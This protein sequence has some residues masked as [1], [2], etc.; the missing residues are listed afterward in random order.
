MG[1]N[2]EVSATHT[3]EATAIL[4]QQ[5]IGEKK[6]IAQ[7]TEDT[8]EQ[9]GPDPAYKNTLEYYRSNQETTQFK[10]EA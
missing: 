2:E 5:L 4:L 8:M 9:V 7:A 10:T 1:W 3:D 6:A